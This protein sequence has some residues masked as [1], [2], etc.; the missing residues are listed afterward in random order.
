MNYF[1]HLEAIQVSQFTMEFTD[2]K[3]NSI[4][5][6]K[7]RPVIFYYQPTRIDKLLALK[8]LK[9][10][11]SLKKNFFFVA[12]SKATLISLINVK[13]RLLILK[14]KSTLHAHFHPP[15]LLIS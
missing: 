5:I 15:R 7:C 3:M 12:C 9:S 11:P 1:F 10:L 6:E 14:K 13:A 4:R 2:K 8:I